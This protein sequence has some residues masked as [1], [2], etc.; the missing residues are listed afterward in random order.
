MSTMDLDN[1]IPDKG[2][3]YKFRSDS[4]IREP[5]GSEKK[6]K[7]SHYSPIFRESLIYKKKL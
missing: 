5:L 6:Y 3:L 2:D 4:V 1:G 7:Y